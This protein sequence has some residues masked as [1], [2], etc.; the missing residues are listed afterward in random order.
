MKAR[1]RNG[2]AIGEKR[3][4]KRT[5]ECYPPDLARARIRPLSFYSTALQFCKLRRLRGL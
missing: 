1:V 3:D 4:V 5:T 2:S